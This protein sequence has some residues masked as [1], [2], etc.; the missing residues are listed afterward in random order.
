VTVLAAEGWQAEVLAKAAFLG[1]LRQGPALLA[2]AGA[3]G[4]LVDDRG[5]LHRTAGFGRFTVAGP[6]G[7]VLQEV[8]G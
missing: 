2:T 7:R 4:L 5:G 8:A 6:P 1:G 3:D